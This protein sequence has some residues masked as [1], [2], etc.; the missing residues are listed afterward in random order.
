MPTPL[1]VTPSSSPSRNRSTADWVRSLPPELKESFLRRVAPT[2]TERGLLLYDWSFWGR[3]DQ[4]EPPGRWNTWLILSGRGWGKSRT[5]AEWVR[6][7]VEHGRCKRLALVART[8]ADVRDVVVEGESGILA[9]SPPW[10]RPEWEPSKRRLTWPNGA[11]ATTFS[12][13]EPDAL[14]GPQHDGAWCDELAAWRYPEAFDMLQ[15]GLRLGRRPR[16]VVTT[17]PRPV[18]LVKELLADPTTFRTRG[19]TYDNAGNLAATFLRQILRKYEGTRLGR[20]ELHA[21]VLDDT[22]GAL[23]KRDQLEALRLRFNKHPTEFLRVVVAVDPATSTGEGSNETGIVVVGLGLDGEGYV[24][25]DAS[26]TYS[27]AEWG[28]RVVEVYRRWEA[29]RVVAEAN[30]GGNLVESNLRVAVLKDEAGRVLA[31]GEHLPISMVHAS[32]GKR[33]RAEPVS[34]L[35]EQGRVHHVGAFPELEDQLCGWN[36][37]SGEASPD[38]LDALVWGF[39]ALMLG[40]LVHDT[41]DDDYLDLQDDRS[42]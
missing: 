33:A 28:A 41:R 7:Q 34:A 6:R 30:Q 27:P 3:P 4:H 2:P 42:F 11:I 32:K 35:Y 38:R 19:S 31:R 8:A 5:G 21:E 24:L 13:D 12:A 9:I 26:G 16:I 40:T 25:E 36:A 22:P 39:T 23:W 14:R 18:K 20:Q 15:M 10:N 1:I 17:T 37:T 29:D